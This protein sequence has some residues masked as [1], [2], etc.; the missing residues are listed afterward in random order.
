MK[1]KWRRT[2]KKHSETNQS[3]VIIFIFRARHNAGR[4][5]QNTMNALEWNETKVNVEIKTSILN[6]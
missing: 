2:E 1:P 6:I 4:S 5:T 3:Y